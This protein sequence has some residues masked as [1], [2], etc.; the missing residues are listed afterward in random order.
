MFRARLDAAA[1]SL[2]ASGVQIVAWGVDPT[3][4]SVN[5]GA[6]SDLTSAEAA[7]RDALGADVPLMVY[8]HGP[9]TT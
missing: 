6:A 2:I 1:D 8:A 9:V 3:T 4:N 7:L 5:V